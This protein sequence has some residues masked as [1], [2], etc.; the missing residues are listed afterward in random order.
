[1]L[2]VGFLSDWAG[3]SSASWAVAKVDELGVKSILPVEM[4]DSKASPH[5]VKSALSSLL[6]ND[7]RGGSAVRRFD[8]PVIPVREIGFAESEELDEWSA[9]GVEPCV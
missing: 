4:P 2:T 9:D 1:M 6:C 3:V 7:N 5:S 8:R